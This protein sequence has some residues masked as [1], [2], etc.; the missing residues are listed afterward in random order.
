MDGMIVGHVIPAVNSGNY[1]IVEKTMEIVRHGKWYKQLSK[2]PS[3]IATGG[4]RT[5][6]CSECG[7]WGRKTFAYCPHCGAKMDDERMD[8]DGDA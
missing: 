7:G 2:C 4:S 6:N 1:P 3:A 5:F 8:G